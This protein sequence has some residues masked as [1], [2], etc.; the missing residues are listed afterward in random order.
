ML[1]EL[2]EAS[3]DVET[4]ISIRSAKKLVELLSLPL[5]CVIKYKEIFEL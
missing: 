5:V 3:P 4:G 1:L 2:D